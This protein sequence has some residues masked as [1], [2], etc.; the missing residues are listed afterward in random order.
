MKKLWLFVLFHCSVVLVYGQEV[1]TY[2][3]FKFIHQLAD[4][5][6]NRTAEFIDDA[7]KEMQLIA[8]FDSGLTKPVSL[9]QY[10]SLK[11]RVYIDT[12]IDGT[13]TI[14]NP[15][16]EFSTLI[17]SYTNGE[18]DSWSRISCQP[19]TIRVQITKERYFYLDR[20]KF[21]QLYKPQNVFFIQQEISIKRH[22]EF[23]RDS[24]GLQYERVLNGLAKR[25]LIEVLSGKYVLS[26]PYPNIPSILVSG[27]TQFTPN[28]IRCSLFSTLVLVDCDTLNLDTLNTN[29]IAPKI[30]G[31]AF[32]WDYQ[33]EFDSFVGKP[34]QFGLSYHPLIAGN[35][36]ELPDNPLFWMD[37]KDFTSI[38][39]KDELEILLA[40]LFEF[41]CWQLSERYDDNE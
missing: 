20:A 9:P 8:Y 33:R 26:K 5:S 13:D 4:A 28:D 12:M 37:F 6:F 21:I 11:I 30:T 39:T 35:S 1:R 34:I 10:D 40:V 14:I 22:G 32:F 24:I 3:P 41:Q 31:F 23:S 25:T 19:N 16:D 29:I 36:I 15:Y 27:D 7:I 2:I 38:A 17:V 18:P